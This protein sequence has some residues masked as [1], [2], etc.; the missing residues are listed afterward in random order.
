MA[1]HPDIQQVIDEFNLEEKRLKEMIHEYLH[2]MES[3]FVVAWQYQ[4]EL[5]RIQSKL[6]ILNK[7]VD[8]GI[9]QTE[10]SI[11]QVKK[12]LSTDKRS[13]FKVLY[14]QRL[15]ELN[16]EL[17]NQI[18][19]KALPG[20]HDLISDLLRK[21]LFKKISGFGL[22]AQS[23]SIREIAFTSVRGNLRISF[24][25]MKKRKN[26]DG[27]LDYYL[28]ILENLN[29][30]PDGKGKVWSLTFKG[31]KEE[32]HYK[33]MAVLARLLL[34]DKIMVMSDNYVKIKDIKNS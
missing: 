9:W 18:I 13:H 24:P 14:E 25:D 16:E 17:A 29:F 31:S 32:Q 7:L 26:D 34:E 33:A 22:H 2:G 19:R 21:T 15:E 27:M 6:K 23:G 12:Y 28:R 1:N 30:S 20:N 11:E 5:Y 3:D 8:F 4:K 10:Q